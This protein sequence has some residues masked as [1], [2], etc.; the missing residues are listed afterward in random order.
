[1]LIQ[2]GMT[3]NQQQLLLMMQNAYPEVQKQA[4]ELTN[5]IELLKEKIRFIAELKQRKSLSGAHGFF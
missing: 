3:Q 1:M 4:T 2:A 5:I